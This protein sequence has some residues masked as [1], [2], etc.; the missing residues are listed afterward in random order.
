MDRKKEIYKYT[1]TN[2]RVRGDRTHAPMKILY[3][4]IDRQD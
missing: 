3:R 2:R 4:D 1:H